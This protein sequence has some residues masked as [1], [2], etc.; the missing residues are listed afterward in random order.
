M[1]HR[2]KNGTYQKQLGEEKKKK[3]VMGKNYLTFKI[4]CKDI[5][6]MNCYH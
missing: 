3:E 5:K 4:I 2:T 1:I 6:N